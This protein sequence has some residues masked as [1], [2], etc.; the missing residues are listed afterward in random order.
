MEK[1]FIVGTNPENK[2]IA[3]LSNSTYLVMP[4]FSMGE[5]GEVKLSEYVASQIPNDITTCVI[6]V[7]CMENVEICLAFAM[8]L[9][10]SLFD[11]HSAAFVPILFASWSEQNVFYGYKYS[12]IILTDRIIIEKPTNISDAL[13]Y[14]RPL[15][16]KEYINNFLNVV[17][18]LPNAIEGRHSL[19]NQWGAD[20]MCRIITG[21]VENAL[22]KKARLSLYF[23]YTLAL[24]LSSQ[25]IQVLEEGG[26]LKFNSVTLPTL[27]SI[28]KNILL[29]DD[30]AD[31]GWSE[32]LQAILKGSKFTTV[33]RK[34]SSYEELPYDIRQNFENDKYDLI[35]LDLRMNG[36]QEEAVLNPNEFSG[37]KILKAIK[38]V[39]KGIQVI[40]LTASNKAWNMK[41]LMDAGA[42]GYYI[43]ESPELAFSNSYSEG[44]ARELLS[45][46]KRCLGN[47]FLRVFYVK[48]KKLKELISKSSLFGEKTEEILS[49]IDIAYDLL[50]HSSNSNEYKSYSY[51]QLFL[52]IEEYVKLSSVFDETDTGLYLCNGERRYRILKDKIISDKGFIYDSA[53]SWS[54][55][56]FIKKNGK[57]N[58]KIDTNFLVS[59]VL[60]YKFGNEN[61]S[62]KKWTDVYKV[63]NQKAAHPK[64]SSVSIEEFKKILDFMLYF[65]DKKNEKWRNTNQAFPEMTGEEQLKMLKEKFC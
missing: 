16:A 13:K 4:S 21:G 26:D 60:I 3:S 34:I 62:V 56:K 8:T 32:A 33:C 63:R 6:D 52:T 31:K 12:A 51:L 58:R 19:A 48:I 36:I 14:L 27:D 47:G 43:K 39:N 59:A 1:I 35:F 20:V 22:I 46:V 54:N 41:A 64:T 44:N 17:K 45:C 61:S 5:D 28:G 50:A 7:D 25:Q 55:G 42:D 37:M 10:L 9:R 30:E 65:F 2:W 23:R 49:S 40:M 29:I 57:Y 15:T 24:T 38:A 11:K 18:I 53:I